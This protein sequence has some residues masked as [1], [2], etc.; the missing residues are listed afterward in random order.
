MWTE[1]LALAIPL[2][3]I[4]EA[5]ALG[6]I[7][8]PDSGGSLTFSPD[9]TIGDYVVAYVPFT[10]QMRGVVERRIAAEWQA[11]INQRAEQKD[12]EPLSPETIEALR[13][14][15][16]VGDEVAALESL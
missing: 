13:A 2:T 11:A 9:Q 7:I 12:M 3:L 16:L 1:R 15:L 14:A 8:D 10:K 5:N 4:A 6:A